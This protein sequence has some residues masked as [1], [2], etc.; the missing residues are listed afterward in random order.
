[1]GT[2]PNQPKTPTRSFR[3]SDDVYKPALAKAREEGT[4]LT[5]V[6]TSALLDYIEDDDEET[7]EG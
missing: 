3:I 6:V 2:V 5:D 7:G 1:M 4:T